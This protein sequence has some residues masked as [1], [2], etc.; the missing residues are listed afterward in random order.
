MSTSVQSFSW[1]GK[2]LM[3]SRLFNL[4]LCLNS[5][6]YRF[7]FVLLVK[8]IVSIIYSILFFLIFFYSWLFSLSIWLYSLCFAR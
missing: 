1:V 8:A 5:K 4:I 6:F 2:S 3:K 7:N